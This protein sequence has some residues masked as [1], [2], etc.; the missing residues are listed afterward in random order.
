MPI[1]HWLDKER[2][3]VHAVVTGRFTLA[4]IV[5]AIDA[6]TSDPEFERG[7]DVLSDHTAVEEPLT[8]SQAEQM[9]AHLRT[10]SRQL[11]GARWA[12]VTRKPASYG[13]MRMLSVL[14]EQVP[15]RV[16]V[17]NSLEEAEQWL[18]SGEGRPR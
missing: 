6:A 13:M 7:F 14:A 2:R 9:V 3:R 18:G 17:L 12:I 11:V 15:M 5:A 4:E 10:L 1:R 16:E 8:P